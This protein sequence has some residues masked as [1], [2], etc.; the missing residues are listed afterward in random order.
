M[1]RVALRAN[2][3]LGP[4]NKVVQHLEVSLLNVLGVVLH[5]WFANVLARRFHLDG[6][7]GKDD[8]RLTA[9]KLGTLD[10]KGRVGHGLSLLWTGQAVNSVEFR[11]PWKRVELQIWQSLLELI[12]LS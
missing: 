11:V 1:H 10:S 4:S 8:W 2:R 3:L 5:G 6:W 9:V 12:D 7:V